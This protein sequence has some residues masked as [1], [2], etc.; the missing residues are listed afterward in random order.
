MKE[1]STLDEITL[2]EGW[3][4][5]SIPLNKSLFTCPICFQFILEPVECLECGRLFCKE[6]YSNYCEE[7]SNC[8]CPLCKSSPWEITDK[9][10]VS[11][12]N[13]LEGMKY[14]C[15][16]CPEKNLVLKELVTHLKND[17]GKKIKGEEKEIY[18]YA[19]ESTDKTMVK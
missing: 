12:K 19:V 3:V 13:M 7:K 10:H 9:I 16:I 15:G 1:S 5:S 11:Y 18:E 14:K 17:H 4:H 2:S 6:D 8:A